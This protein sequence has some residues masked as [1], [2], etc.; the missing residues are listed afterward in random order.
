MRIPKTRQLWLMAALLAALLPEEA[1]PASIFPVR[2][3]MPERILGSN[4]ATISRGFKTKKAR[5]F[6]A[7]KETGDAPHADE[8]C[9]G[10]ACYSKLGFSIMLY[11]E[12][13]PRKEIPDCGGTFSFAIHTSTTN[14]PLDGAPVLFEYTLERFPELEPVLG[15]FGFFN[16][17]AAYVHS[18]PVRYSFVTPSYGSAAVRVL[19]KEPKTAFYPLEKGWALVF[20]FRW[21]EFQDRIPFHEGKY[22]IGW[23]LTATR[24]REDGTTATWGTLA[25]PVILS[26]GRPGDAFVDEVA[27]G[28]FMENML[29]KHYRD[30]MSFLRQDWTTYR[31]ERWVAALDLGLE[32]FE[33]KNPVSDD[34]FFTRIVGPIFEAN[35]NIDKAIYH[36]VDSLK[37][38]YVPRPKVADFSKAKRRAIVAGLDRIIFIEETIENARRDYLLA[39]FFGEEV[40]T[41]V[42]PKTAKPKKL[43]KIDAGALSTDD[44]SLDDMDGMDIE[45]DDVG[46]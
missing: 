32:T 22:P 31:Q 30:T 43:E 7:F 16:N 46:F 10:S 35:D 14:G 38:E 23:R 9:Y 29:G 21:Q 25:D 34:L 17:E 8:T 28:Y 41:H 44:L 13:T 15:T 2:F 37:K 26:W 6:M 24:A 40:P 12:G 1:R 33:K 18:D 4:P 11:V 39:R 20:S 3:G 36:N 19:P 42:V 5:E 27:M 45:L